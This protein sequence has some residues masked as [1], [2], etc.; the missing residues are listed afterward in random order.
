MREHL[1]DLYCVL[2]TKNINCWQDVAPLLGNLEVR[3]CSA[4]S[5][6]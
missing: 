5:V 3:S 6:T 2:V 4:P 1:T